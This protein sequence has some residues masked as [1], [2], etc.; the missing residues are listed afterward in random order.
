MYFIN[1]KSELDL[2]NLGRNIKINFLN[3]FFFFLVEEFLEMPVYIINLTSIKKLKKA[4][5]KN[6]SKKSFHS[7]SI[8]VEKIKNCIVRG[9]DP[10]FYICFQSENLLKKWI[11]IYTFKSLHTINACIFCIYIRLGNIKRFCNFSVIFFKLTMIINSLNFNNKKRL[12]Y[13]ATATCFIF[14][15][16]FFNKYFT[17]EWYLL[18]FNIFFNSFFLIFLDVF[19]GKFIKCNIFYYYFIKTFNEQKFLIKNKIFL[20]FFMCTYLNFQKKKNDPEICKIDKFITI[21]NLKKANIFFFSFKS[22]FNMALSSKKKYFILRYFY[23]SKQVNSLKEKILLKIFRILIFY[24]FT[25]G[26]FRKKFNFFLLKNKLLSSN[27]F[28]KNNPKKK[29]IFSDIRNLLITIYLLK[30]LNNKNE[31]NLENLDLFCINVLWYFNYVNKKGRINILMEIYVIFKLSLNYLLLFFIKKK[32]LFE[33]IESLFKNKLKIKILGYNLVKIFKLLFFYNSLKHNCENFNNYF[34]FSIFIFTYK[35]AL[36][37]KIISNLKFLWNFRVFYF[38]NRKTAII[39]DTKNSIKLNNIKLTDELFSIKNFIKNLIFLNNGTKRFFTLKKYKKKKTKL[40]FNNIIINFSAYCLL[41]RIFLYIY[42]KQKIVEYNRTK[43]QFISFSILKFS[44][45]FKYLNLH[46]KNKIFSATNFNSE[47]KKNYLGIIKKIDL[48][49]KKYIMLNFI[50]RKVSDYNSFIIRDK[51]LQFSIINKILDIFHK[52]NFNLFT[53][54]FKFVLYCIKIS[55]KEILKKYF[56]QIKYKLKIKE[57][58]ESFPNYSL[59]NNFWEKKMPLIRI[60]S[61]IYWSNST[62]SNVFNLMFIITLKFLIW[63][64]SLSFSHKLFIVDPALKKYI[65]III[66]EFF[67]FLFRICNYLILESICYKILTWLFYQKKEIHNN[68]K[69]NINFIL[70]IFCFEYFSFL[71]GRVRR[72]KLWLSVLHILLKF[73]YLTFSKKKRKFF[74]K[75]SHKIKIKKNLNKTTFFNFILQL[76][77][78][79]N[80]KRHLYV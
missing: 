61:N 1:N 74:L 37:Y 57:I 48:P 18:S 2:R 25:K 21:L 22:K 32:F 77:P 34:F 14:K 8:F 38:N 30:Y 16:I 17:K 55:K 33:K 12:E 49:Y 39:F 64:N 52:K 40:L 45:K 50:Y 35:S 28:Y 53:T 69:K 44:N 42:K 66:N 46:V 59:K 9:I 4:F 60:F 20:D 41:I 29:I 27:K 24:K 3:N 10:T 75:K 5:M 31:F 6:L 63:L 47:K 73:K 72:W 58:L 54:I 56:S 43:I 71:L 68:I 70:Y 67:S 51:F 23:N 7:R 26:L 79:Y 13:S 80:K 65:R 78:I 76:F 36:K 11:S 19:C 15:V 62:K